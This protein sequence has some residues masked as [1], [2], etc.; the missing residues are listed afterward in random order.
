MWG[1][2][3]DWREPVDNCLQKAQDRK[4]VFFSFAELQFIQATAQKQLYAVI[5]TVNVAHFLLAK[6]RN[7]QKRK[8][9]TLSS[10]RRKVAM[11]C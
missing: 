7:S 6:F 8:M 9:Y 2:L 5:Q 4:K 1:G 3:W 11:Y 10:E